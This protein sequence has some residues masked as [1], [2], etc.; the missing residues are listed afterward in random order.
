MKRKNLIFV[1]L[2][3]LS[4]LLT[5]QSCKKESP[6]GFTEE[7]AFTIPTLVAPTQGFLNVTG[8]SVDLK[9]ES[10][11]AGAAPNNW[12]VYF[13]T[14]DDP[15][16]IQ[17]GVTTETVTVPVVPGKKYNWK[18]IGTDANGKTTAGPIWSFETVDPAALLDVSMAWTTDIKTVIGIDVAPDEAVNLRMLIYKSDKVTLAVPAI[19][20]ASFQ[21]FPDFST[22]PDGDYFIAADIA[23]T[24]NAGDFNKVFDISINLTFKQRGIVSEIIPFTNVITNDFPCSDYRTFLVKVTKTGNTFTTEQSVSNVTPAPPAALAGVWYGSD[25]G[26]T[27]TIVTTIVDGNLLIDGV[28][29]GWISDMSK[30]GW[31]EVPQSTIPA[32]VL[33]NT[34]NGTVTIPNQKFM[35]TKYK[36]V[37]QTAYYIQGKG[38]Y[39]LSGTFPTMTLNYDFIQGGTSIAS[40]GFGVTSFKAVITLDPAAAKSLE[41]APRSVMKGLLDKPHVTK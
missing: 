39:N 6:V 36:G 16:L 19:D 17:T 32:Q 26:Y 38:T 4:A 29:I 1:M 3:V 18:V 7:Q 23:S 30:T 25:F 28:G 33:I 34:C 24:V 2:L 12:A 9:W 35:V 11:N 10:T 13:G 40:A 15:A 27:S 21:D 41:V 14:G 5:I 8:T 31:G 37:I 20:G 22:L